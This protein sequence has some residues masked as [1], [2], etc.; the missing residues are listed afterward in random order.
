M[1]AGA[2]VRSADV[3]G[4]DQSSH[5]HVYV[6]FY[7]LYIT[8]F[9]TSVGGA[10]KTPRRWPRSTSCPSAEFGPSAPTK[11][12]KSSR[13]ASRSPS[14]LDRMGK[15]LS[16]PELTR[17]WLHYFFLSTT[18][19]QLLIFMYLF[20]FT[21]TYRYYLYFMQFNPNAAAARRPLSNR[22]SM[23]SPAVCPRATSPARPSSTIPRA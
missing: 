2:G 1:V 13:S 19:I 17:C 20:A 22:S 7:L 10:G 14:S 5:S 15:F 3:L 4:S 9:S 21:L 23:P 11:K 6:P 8:D 12:S 18:D 16:F